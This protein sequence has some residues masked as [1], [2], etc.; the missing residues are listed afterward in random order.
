[1]QHHWVELIHGY[2]RR[3]AMP[4]HAD[5]R[6]WKA[7]ARVEE[8]LGQ[9]WSLDAIASVANMSGENFRKLCLKAL[10]RSPMKHLTYLRMRKAAELLTTTDDKVETVARELGYENPFA[11]SNTFLKWIGVRPSEHRK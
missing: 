9:D 10:G 8:N 6:V 2:V 4:L 3:F 5:D 7:W 11:F 1:M